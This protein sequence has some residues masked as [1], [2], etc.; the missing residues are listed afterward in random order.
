M[1]VERIGGWEMPMGRVAVSSA[2]DAFAQYA[3]RGRRPMRWRSRE[4]LGEEDAEVGG[5][6]FRAGTRAP[7]QGRV[8]GTRGPSQT[9]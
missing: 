9:P 3:P 7:S 1:E 6:P 2:V 4:T 8:P 5:E